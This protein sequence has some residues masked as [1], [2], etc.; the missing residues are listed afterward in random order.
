LSIKT[1][2]SALISLI[3]T[4]ILILNNTLYYYSTKDALLKDQEKQMQAIAGEITI[5]IEHSQ[6]GSKYVEGLIGKDLRTAAIAAQFELNPDVHQVTNEQLRTLSNKLGVSDITLFSPVGH[7]IMGMKSSDPKEVGLSTKDWGYWYDAM[8]Q[9][10]DQH[11]TTIS[12]GQKLP[13]YWAGPID[14]ASSDPQH[15]NKWG[16]YYDGTTNYII[17]PYLKDEDIKE[18]ERLTGPKA[19]VDKTLKTNSSLL[20]ITAFNPKTF[21]KDPVITKNNGVEY[22]ELGNRPVLFGDYIY[23]DD[24]RDLASI[25]KANEKGQIDSYEAVVNGK[26]VI[27]SFIPIAK[28]TPYVIGVVTDYKVIQDVLNEH[29]RKNLL[30]SVLLL[31]IIFLGC[32]YLAGRVVRPV[33]HILEK[34]GEIS[35]GRFGA[36]VEINSRDELGDLAN[37]VNIMSRN[38][39]SYTDELKDKQEQIQYQADHDPLTGLPNRRKFNERLNEALCTAEETD[40]KV[41]LMYLDV[42]RFKNINDTLG[43]SMGDLLLQMVA[44]RLRAGVREND[45]VSRL[46]GDEFTVIV[47][48]CKQDQDV[49]AVVQRILVGLSEPFL[50]NG[51]ELFISPS[52]GIARFPD[53]GA[54]METLLIHA[55][56]AMYQSKEQGGNSYSFYTSS[57]NSTASERMDLE[58]RLRKALERD[59]FRLYY[60]P[61]IDMKTHQ[62]TGLETLIRWHNPE[63]GIVSPARF[64]P[65]AEETGMIIPVGA[66]VLRTACVQAKSWQ[67]AGFPP[68]RVA[69]NLSARQVQHLELIPTVKQVLEE[70]GLEADWLEFEITESTLMQNTDRTLSTLRELKQMG[71]QISMDDFG[72]GYSSL[73]YLKRFP[74]DSLKIDQSFVRDIEVADKDAEIVTA[75]INLAHCLK[76]KVIAEGVETEAQQ[77]FLQEHQC[78][79]MQGF[80][81][82]RPLPV[83]ELEKLLHLHQES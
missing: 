15:V 50:L 80:L 9:L 47:D 66:W 36:Q 2:L 39:L 23:K 26:R 79:E 52:I 54:D 20:E 45:F 60:Q 19:I 13:N 44:D 75:I 41:A 1:K 40:C 46:G 74:F 7:D 77:Q 24:T 28:G 65:L 17:D 16:Y 73:N 43:H 32:Y 11:E 38:L 71:I 31:L 12:Q 62:I 21:G 56:T 48:E 61:K 4:I 82:S 5:A 35:E 14:V 53:D 59:E 70:T 78:D 83:E 10:L 37:R 63:M 72:T 18:F 68:M 6:T 69:V 58:N 8:A 64:I 81:F 22:V 49:T 42:D 3:V 27:K 33:Q 67:T 29:L 25:T 51:Y 76:L 30:I 55:D 57:M 34:V